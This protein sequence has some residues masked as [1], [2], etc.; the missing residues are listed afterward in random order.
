MSSNDECDSSQ[1]PVD[2]VRF[3]STTRLIS[4]VGGQSVVALPRCMMYERILR[5]VH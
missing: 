1:A 5:T 2:Q 3:S 4:S